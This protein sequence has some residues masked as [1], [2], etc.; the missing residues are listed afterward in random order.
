VE[1]RPAPGLRIFNWA[2][3][4]EPRWFIND[5]IHYTSAGYAARAHKI[6]TALARGFPAAGPSPGCVVS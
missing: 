4:V 1:R 3:Q 2:A 5:G 6:A